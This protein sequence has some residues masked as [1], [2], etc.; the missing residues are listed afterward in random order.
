[1]VAMLV[2]VENAPYGPASR[3]GN[4]KTGLP[5]ERVH[6]HRFTRFFTGDEVVVITPRVS[7]PNALDDHLC[8]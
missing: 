7:W 4:R 6:G 3:V 5:V 1:M 2:G 8:K